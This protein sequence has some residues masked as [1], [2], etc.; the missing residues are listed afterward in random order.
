MC[1]PPRHDY[2]L[3]AQPRWQPTLTS[4]ERMRSCVSVASGCHARVTIQSVFDGYEVMSSHQDVK[5]R[6]ESDCVVP[7]FQVPS[8]EEVEPTATLCEACFELTRSLRFVDIGVVP[9]A[10]G[11]AHLK[12][13]L[14]EVL[15]AVKCEITEPKEDAPDWYVEGVSVLQGHKLPSMALRV[16]GRRGCSWCL[17]IFCGRLA[18]L[19]QS[20]TG[21]QLS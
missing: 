8:F 1:P 18:L 11:S 15:V 7:W 20:M 14:T 6:N 19:A 9:Q 21:I 13:G 3:L 4:R 16:V 5:F 17:C 10:N 2:F 12:M